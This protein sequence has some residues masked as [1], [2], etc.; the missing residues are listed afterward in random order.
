M[1]PNSRPDY[2]F[3]PLVQ[4]RL[5]RV[6]QGV[7]T[8]LEDMRKVTG[9]LMALPERDKAASEILTLCK[10][11]SDHA[12]EFKQ[13]LNTQNVQFT[14]LLRAMKEDWGFPRLARELAA[15]EQ[16]RVPRADSNL[17]Q[18]VCGNLHAELPRLALETKLIY[19][20][21]AM[22]F[23]NDEL[24]GAM[25]VFQSS[26]LLKCLNRIRNVV[27]HK[28]QLQVREQPCTLGTNLPGT[29]D[30]TDTESLSWVYLF[31]RPDDS[32]LQRPNDKHPLHPTIPP[33]FRKQ[34][35]RFPFEWLLVWG[36]ME[37]CWLF[38]PECQ[39]ACRV[40]R[41]LES[42]NIGRPLVEPAKLVNGTLQRP[43]TRE[44]SPR[45]NT[46]PAPD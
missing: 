10:S 1:T 9:A 11:F 29:E 19:L 28:G 7:R 12:R 21:S 34:C 42:S 5:D 20:K 46:P 18:Q 23:G 37:L 26:P 16:P 15:S 36:Q 44:D 24:R 4:P 41:L 35:S 45:K 17:Q 43:V 25:N 40:V 33:W 13:L 38:D 27:V 39:Q 22:D 14:I 3:V 8:K 31:L 2:Y 6:P 32:D 30:E